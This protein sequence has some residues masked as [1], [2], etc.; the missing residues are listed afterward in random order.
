MNRSEASPEVALHPVP[1]PGEDDEEDSSGGADDEEGGE[2]L[3]DIT[4]HGER[5]EITAGRHG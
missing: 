1:Q 5:E 2:V 4:E 3:Y